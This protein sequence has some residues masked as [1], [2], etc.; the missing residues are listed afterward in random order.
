MLRCTA[1]LPER[2][3]WHGIDRQLP[4]SMAFLY[5]DTLYSKV[6]TFLLRMVWCWSTVKTR[7]ARKIGHVN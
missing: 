7:S 6:I 4:N 1:P 2:A 5:I 3:E